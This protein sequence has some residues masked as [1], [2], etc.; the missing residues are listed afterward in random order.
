MDVSLC[1]NHGVS[2]HSY[3]QYV[4][5]IAQQYLQLSGLPLPEPT[6]LYKPGA[7]SDQPRILI[8]SPHPDDECLMAA[9]AL[10]M[11]EEWGAQVTV[12]PYSYGSNVSRRVSRSQELKD[13]LTILGF[14]LFDPRKNAAY[15]KLTQEE[16]L[17][18]VKHIDP[19][20]I[21]APHAKDRHPTHIEAHAMAC[22]AKSAKLLVQTEYW[23][24]AEEPNLFISLS[25]QHVVKIGEAL[26]KHVGEV[27][28]NPYHLSLPAW[29]MDQARRAPEII[30]SGFGGKGS[31]Y[32]FGQLLH[33][34][35]IR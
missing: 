11:Q 33:M 3:S 2:N 27:A 35:R 9:C 31:N 4:E 13:A 5:S 21:I 17:D 18:A 29:Y 15:E 8:L 16:F 10:R 6:P 1:F 12:V 14:N 30:P 25:T 23:Q 19:E 32:I 26:M 28:R 22:L 34:G 7:I 20:V 24:A